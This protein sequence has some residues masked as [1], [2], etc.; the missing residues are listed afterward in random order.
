[1][2]ALVPGCEF[3][4]IAAAGDKSIPGSGLIL[5]SV[6]LNKVTASAVV[7]LYNGTSTTGTLIGTI[8]ASQSAIGTLTYDILCKNGLY[9][10]MTGAN[11]DITI[12]VI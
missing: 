12:C 6:V 8:D 2:G 11:A 4:N 7:K 1:M 3:F 5:H 10:V 9:A